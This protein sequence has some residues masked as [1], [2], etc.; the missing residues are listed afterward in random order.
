MGFVH[1]PKIVIDN[2]VLC[3]DAANSKSYSDGDTT[4]TDTI[5]S[6]SGAITGATWSNNEFTFDGDNDVISI[7]N[8]T[9]FHFGSGD[10]TVEVWAYFTALTGWTAVYMTRDSHTAF[11]PFL[12]TAYG[13]DLRVYAADGDGSWDIL[14][15]ASFGTISTNTWYQIVVTR[16]GNTFTRYLNTTS[17]GTNTSS[18]TLWANGSALKIGESANSMAGKIPIVRVYKGKALSAVEIKQNY[19]TIKGR[20]GL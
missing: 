9:A 1:S 19:D 15:A 12:I 8:N 3:L 5:G 10:F 6:L 20:Y 4:W 16:S 13:T 17:I 14:N 7:P 2:L 11:S 18:A